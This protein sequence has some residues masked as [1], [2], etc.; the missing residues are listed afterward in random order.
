MDTL[1][2]RFLRYVRIDTRSDEH[3]TTHP[4]TA[5]QLDLSRLLARECEELGLAD[6]SLDPSGVVMA[7]VPATVPHRAPAI[8]WLAHVDT[9]PEFS[10]TNVRP[11]VHENYAGGDIVLPGDPRQV[12]RTSPG[13]GAGALDLQAHFLGDPVERFRAELHGQET[14]DGRTTHVMTLTPRERTSFRALKVWVD[15]RDH[16][17]RRFEIVEENGSVRRFDLSG[18]ELNP[19]LPDD[20]FR[21]T[22]PAGA[23]VVDR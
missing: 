13:G 16:L 3:S 14:L 9:S 11:I 22:P 2:D 6:V 8:A 7:T 17:V 1:L 4:S 23:R 19:R 18:L 5:K 12:I 21:F 10:G 20:L 15:A